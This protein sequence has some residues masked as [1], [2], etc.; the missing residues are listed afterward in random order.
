MN[1]LKIAVCLSGQLRKLPRTKL[2]KLFSNLAPDYYIHTWNDEHNPHLPRVLNFFPDATVE[3]ET[4]AEKFDTLLLRPD[5]TFIGSNRYEFAQF[6]S[7]MRSLEMVKSSG[8]HYDL[9]IRAR[10][11]TTVPYQVFTDPDLF[12][13]GIHDLAADVRRYYIHTDDLNKI[14]DPDQCPFLDDLQN[15]MPFVCTEIHSVNKDVV[16]IADWFWLMNTPALNNLLNFG[17]PEEITRIAY[18]IKA[19]Y[20]SQLHYHGTGNYHLKSPIVWGKVFM[21]A[22]L[23]ILQSTLGTASGIQRS[24]HP[25]IIPCHGDIS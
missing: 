5:E 23:T 20:N 11:D 13:G 15:C 1:K 24:E 8:K 9:I 12:K 4:Y 2:P 6:Y 17:D 19:Q 22:H 14:S 10:T 16:D 25:T 3:T 7:V 21:L 18:N